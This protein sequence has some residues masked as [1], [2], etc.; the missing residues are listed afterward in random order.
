VGRIIDLNIGHDWILKDPNHFNKLTCPVDGMGHFS[1]TNDDLNTEFLSW[2]DTL[3]LEPKMSEMFYCGPGSSIPVHSDDTDP[4]GCCKLD[5]AYGGVVMDW[6]TTDAKLEYYNNTIGGYYLTCDSSLMK[7]NESAKLA[8]PSLVNIG[9]L[10]GVTNHT[11]TP[12]WIVCVVLRKKNSEE[13]R[14]NWD[15][16]SSLLKPYYVR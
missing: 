8:T 13:H 4:P 7:L 12:W 9:D 3:G 2:L 15:E 16:L 11:D 10:H 5:W 1:L 14:I 6:Y